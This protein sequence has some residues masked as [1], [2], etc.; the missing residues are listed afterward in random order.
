MGIM[1]H[2]PPQI[3]DFNGDNDGYQSCYDAYNAGYLAVSQNKS[4]K[5]NPYSQRSDESWW[6]KEGF[7]DCL[8]NIW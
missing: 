2:N 5:D 3:S 4:P 8:N 6:W 7:Y 1:S